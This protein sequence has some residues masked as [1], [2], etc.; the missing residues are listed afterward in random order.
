MTGKDDERRQ[1]EGRDPVEGSEE[2]GQTDNETGQSRGPGHGHCRH[3][4][5]GRGFSFRLGDSPG[6]HIE[7]PEGLRI[8]ADKLREGLGRRANVVMVRVNEEVLEKL[9]DLVEAGIFKSQSESAAFLIQEGIKAQETMFQKI[10]EHTKRI[11][12]LRD[13]LKSLVNPGEPPKDK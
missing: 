12:E 5:H 2:A 1:D 7:G 10:G 11:R 3:E 4:G 8:F 6:I 9:E 13:E